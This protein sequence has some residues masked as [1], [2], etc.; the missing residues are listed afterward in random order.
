MKKT[1]Y[2]A[3]L[4]AISLCLFAAE[5]L[6][7]PI[8]PL[9][10]VKPGLANVI[11][12]FILHSDGFKTRDALLVLI[13]RVLLSA[14][15]TGNVFAVLFGLT[16]GIAAVFAMAALRKAFKGETVPAVSVAGAVA[17]NVGQTLVA[18]AVYKSAAV[19]FYLP[20]LT[21]GGIASGLFTG[22]IA[23]VILKRIK[24]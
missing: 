17:H 7:P 4:T 2:L 12:L 19:L 6:I 20:A 24:R 22:I 1:A 11:T 10:G 21:L 15:V 8:V 23:S 14:F 13:A 9:P 3:L 5:L 18:A 16:G